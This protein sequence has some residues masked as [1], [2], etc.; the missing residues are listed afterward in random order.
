M[1]VSREAIAVRFVRRLYVYH[2]R[3]QLCRY[4]YHS[5][6]WGVRYFRVDQDHRE[7]ERVPVNFPVAF[8][9]GEVAGKGWVSDISMGGCTIRSETQLLYTQIVKVLLQIPGNNFPLTLNAPVLRK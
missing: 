8:V 7:Y 6:Q 1:N 9:S 3:C 5:V 4:R 2:V